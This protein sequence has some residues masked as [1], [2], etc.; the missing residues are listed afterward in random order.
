MSCV[1]TSNWR[2]L[3]HLEY[4]TV[5]HTENNNP[6]LIYRFGNG[7]IPIWMLAGVHGNEKEGFLFSE[8]YIHS[9]ASNEFALPNN[10]SLYITPRL[11]V[12]GCAVSRRTNANNVDLNRNLPTKDWTNK[13]VEPK[14]YPG[15]STGS[16]KETTITMTVIKHIKPQL[17]ISLHSYEEAMINYNGDCKDIAFEMSRHNHL[18]PKGD[19]GYPTPGSLGTYAGFELGIP[20]ITLEIKRGQDEESTWTQHA[21]AMQETFYFFANKFSS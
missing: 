18:E 6:I 7:A 5:D 14:Y 13:F 8:Q 1:H 19:I 2:N 4:A 20:T 12:D 16:E 15:K 10:I 3:E 11:N 9:L 17:I 21:K